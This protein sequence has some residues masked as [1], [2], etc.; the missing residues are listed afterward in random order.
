MAN[1]KRIKDWLHRNP[2]P[3]PSL[4]VSRRR[5]SWERWRGT[6]GCLYSSSSKETSEILHFLN[7]KHYPIVYQ[8]TDEEVTKGACLFKKKTTE[9]ICSEQKHIYHTRVK[10]GKF[11]LKF[12]T[13][14][15][16]LVCLSVRWCD[17]R[18]IKIFEDVSNKRNFMS[19]LG[20]CKKHT[21]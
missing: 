19:S 4:F 21:K 20:N 3:E 15:N 11:L 8:L 2:S 7:L 9:R 6:V 12:V 17:K 1:I 18:S 10:L 5:C 14:K 16:A 13:L